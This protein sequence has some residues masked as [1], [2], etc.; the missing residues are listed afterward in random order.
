ATFFTLVLEGSRTIDRQRAELN[1]RISDLS[2]AMKKGEDLG[3]RV[4]RGARDA[5]EE[6]ERFL[7]I[8]GSELHD[9]PTQLIGL[10]RLRLDQVRDPQARSHVDAI[11]S[12]L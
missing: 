11:R 9:G 4:E 10:A 7:K 8:V 5:I 12:A 6:N 1:A 3:A 2:E